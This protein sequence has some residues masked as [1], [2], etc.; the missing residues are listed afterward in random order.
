MGGTSVLVFL[1]GVS[2]FGL[3][4]YIKKH[5]KAK[6]EI[7]KNSNISPCKNYN[8]R[9]NPLKRNPKSFKRVKL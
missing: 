3:A 8:L 6:E 4:I 9:Q 7:W 5:L 1:W 2:H